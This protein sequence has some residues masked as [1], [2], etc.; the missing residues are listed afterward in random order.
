M[1]HPLGLYLLLFTEFWERFSYYGMRSLLIVYMTRQLQFSTRTAGLIYGLYTGLAYLTP[2][3]GGYLADRFMGQRRAIALGGTLIAMG[4]LAMT[5]TSLPFFFTALSLLV[6]GTGFFKANTAVLVG[7]LYDEDDPRREDG[8]SLFYLCINIGG[9][10]APIVC[11]TLVTHGHWHLGFGAAGLGMLGGLVVYVRCQRVLGEHGLRPQRQGTAQGAEAAPL[12]LVQKHRIIALIILALVGN[13]TLWA[14]LSQAGSS[15]A[16][17]ADRETNLA[18]PGLGWS[19]PASYMQAI[20]PLFIM[21]G[22]PAFSLLWRALAKRHCEPNAPQKFILGILLVACGFAVLIGAG[23][24]ADTGAKVGMGWLI[25]ASLLHTCGEL[26]V[27]PVGLSLVTK[28]SPKRYASALMGLWYASL[29]LANGFGGELAARYDSL[30]KAS[31][32]LIPTLAL[33][34]TACLLALL[35][36]PLQRLMHGIR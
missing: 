27:S 30:S 1:R 11:G 17:F 22:V 32:F 23:Y 25:L 2:V 19:L 35:T 36:R 29:A 31:L 21:L 7:A 10:L 9:V 15:M 33:A 24:V 5:V 28:L 20:N 26:C 12:T 8:F 6:L 4:H 18:I 13:V 3:F 34:L 16:L 14:A